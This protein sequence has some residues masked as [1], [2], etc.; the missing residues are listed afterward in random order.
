MNYCTPDLRIIESIMGECVIVGPQCDRDL[1][2]QRS[3]LGVTN[4][5]WPWLAKP[6]AQAMLEQMRT[7]EEISL[8]AEEFP[9][10]NPL[11]GTRLWDNS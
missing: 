10:A 7:L 4:P 8:V 9:K 3:Y 1:P 11:D 6:A 5:F 2:G